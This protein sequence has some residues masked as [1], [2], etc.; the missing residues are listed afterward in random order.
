MLADKVDTSGT[1]FLDIIR[2]QSNRLSNHIEK[3]LELASL[4]QKKSIMS[5]KVIDFHP[6]LEQLCLDFD[7]L[8]VLEKIDFSYSL[9][10]GEYSIKGE[11]FHL[12]NMVSNLLDNAKK[13]ANDPKIELS[14]WKENG[15]LNIQV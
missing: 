15:H 6:I 3:V 7:T 11:P 9:E 10:V 8:T 14:S 1:K 4:E 12:R 13:Y 2:Q 5:L